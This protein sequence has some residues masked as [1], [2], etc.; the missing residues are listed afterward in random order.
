MVAEGGVEVENVD[1]VVEEVITVD[2]PVPVSDVVKVSTD[3]VMVDIGFTV[4]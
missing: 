4:P 2:V 3:C 1:F